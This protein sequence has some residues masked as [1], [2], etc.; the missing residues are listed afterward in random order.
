MQIA[1]NILKDPERPKFRRLKLTNNKIR[2]TI[3]EVPGAFQLLTSL[4]SFPPSKCSL[5]FFDLI[6]SFLHV[7]KASKSSLHLKEKAIWI[8]LKR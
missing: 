4:G 6:N 3:L 8:C 1:C 7:S 2:K 5:I